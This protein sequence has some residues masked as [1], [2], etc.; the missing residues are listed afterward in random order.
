MVSRHQKLRALKL[1]YEAEIAEAK[2]DIE[3]Y[4][5]YS[6]GVAE[7]PRV[8]ESLDGLVSMLANAEDKLNSLTNNFVTALYEQEKT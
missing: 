8:V 2:A 3:N 6:V 1:K 7:H 4:L 5:E